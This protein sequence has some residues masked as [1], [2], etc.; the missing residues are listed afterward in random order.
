MNQRL[1]VAVGILLGGAGIAVLAVLAG[2]EPYR[3]VGDP[4][5]GALVSI[6]APVLRLL[7][8]I[9][10]AGCVGALGFTTLC[11]RPRASGLVSAPGYAELRLAGHAATAWAVLAALLVPWSAAD[12]TGLPLGTVLRPAAL[13]GLLSASEVPEA[14][15]VTAVAATAVAL[16]CRLVLR[17]RPAF[18]LLATALFA[19]LPP[20]VTGHGSADLG[21][22]L[23][24]AAIVVHVPA[25]A[26]WFGGLLTVLRRKRTPGLVQR[27]A[28][29][30][31]VCWLVLLASGLVLALV[32]VPADGLGSAY[33][34]VLVVKA[35]V[36]LALGTCGWALRRRA[37][38][39]PA[40]V[41]ALAGL[42]AMSAGL[43]HLSVPDVLDRAS[44][45][46]QALLGYD[47][48]GP[49]TALRLLTDWRVDVLFVPVA[50]VLAMGY[51]T[52]VRRVRSY[53]QSWP[54]GRTVAWLAGC[55][56]LV[57]ATSSGL[58]RYA[59]AMFSM[60]MAAHML[61]SMLVP[62]L[63]VLGGPLTLVRTAV[64]VSPG[65]PGLRDWVDRLSDS[66]LPRALTQPLVA[67]MLFAG[68]PFVL[69]FTGLFD[70]A[71]RFHWAHLA[72]D[73]WFLVVGYLF[74]WPVIGTDPLPRPLPNL[75]RLGMLL[76]A[77][78]ADIL[79]GALVISTPRLLGD[80][81]ASAQMYSALALP[82]VH[83]L[84]GDQRLAG[85]LA[86][87]LGELALL[88]VLG[89]LLAR[90]TA[91]DKAG[92]PVLSLTAR[93]TGGHL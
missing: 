72:I 77:M 71:A 88:V 25:A 57:L 18:L 75:A 7:A 6:G 15:L 19:L 62:A 48:D 2:A 30:A 42:F 33:G 24:L 92:E 44:T 93:E 85:V 61:L 14:W 20:L 83:D 26:L 28:T 70:A 90:W 3:A 86:L 8:D 64:P 41:L 69:Y 47:L 76:A 49:P 35:L 80:G 12:T 23:A 73:A 10:G 54:A 29:L 1:V 22:D 60:H 65:L 4:D 81:P 13:A 38:F 63:L 50:G 34:L 89:A 46:T 32:L 68:S 53:G 56:V 43:T 79:F 16:G 67:L 66:P 84:H 39:W 59:A 87:V 91:V 9:T 11:T 78:P 82:W 51:L 74:L 21:H 37:W 52:G 58:G 27:Y 5:P 45:T 36:A 55:A 17:W 40:E 31:A